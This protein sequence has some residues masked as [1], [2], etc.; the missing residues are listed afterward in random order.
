MHFDQ[1]HLSDEPSIQ[2]TLLDRAPALIV[3]APVA[4]KP[5]PV[6]LLTLGIAWLF[7]LEALLTDEDFH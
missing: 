5:T 3:S 1:L 7:G 2:P 4:P 6:G